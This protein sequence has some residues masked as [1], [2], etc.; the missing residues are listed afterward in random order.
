MA[1]VNKSRGKSSK[2]SLTIT[3]MSGRDRYLRGSIPVKSGSNAMLP[4][5]ISPRPA[6]R[7]PC[8]KQRPKKLILLLRDRQSSSQAVQF[9][10]ATYDAARTAAAVAK[11]QLQVTIA[12]DRADGSGTPPSRSRL[13][14][15]RYPLTRGRSLSS[16][17]S[18]SA[19][20]WLHPCSLP[21]YSPSPMTCAAWRSSPPSTRRACAAWPEGHL[22]LKPLIPGVSSKARSS[23]SGWVRKPCPTW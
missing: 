8:R 4:G 1:A 22:Q 14:Q 17:A 5:L 2:F 18:S 11:A 15:Y 13:V 20:R 16:A 23:T 10:E 21:R 7:S 19:R 3:T 9:S 12:Q 6:P